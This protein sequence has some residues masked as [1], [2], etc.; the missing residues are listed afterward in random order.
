MSELQH[1]LVG[2]IR[3][4]GPAMVERADRYDREASFPDENFADLRD[5]GFLGLCIPRGDGG[6]GADFTTYARVAEELGRHCG[7]T[8]LAFNMHTATTLLAGQISDEL[9]LDDGDRAILARRRERLY[10]GILDDDA[11]HA[12]PFSEGLD[13]RATKGFATMAEPTDGGYLVSGKKIFASLS[14]SADVHNVACM[15]E[16]DPRI[17]LL[18]VPAGADGLTVTGEWDPLGMR[19]TVSKTLLLDK[20]F[21]PADNEWLPP[22]VFNQMATRWPHFYMTLS[23]AYVGVM[24]AIADFTGRYLSGE[25]DGASRAGNPQ[26]EYV[27]GDIQVRYEQA[28]ALSHTASAEAG[29]DPSPAMLRRAWSS[30]VATM[31]GAPT[32]ASAAVQACGGRSLLRPLPLERLYRDARCGATMLPW[33]AEVCRERL[34]SL[35]AGIEGTAGRDARVVGAADP[36]ADEMVDE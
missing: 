18:G 5:A 32:I 12:Q 16:G 36:D 21:V 24:G 25:I 8:A 19:G 6:L 17:R 30:V 2:R 34:G 3:E 9:H 28:R 14:T 31:E 13:P 10:A 22:G 11:I 26:K 7:S 27:W 1:E 23:F 4:L 33:S 29:P 20:V 35:K 15:V